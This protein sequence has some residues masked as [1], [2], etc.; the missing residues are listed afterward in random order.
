MFRLSKKSEYAILALQYLA[1]NNNRTISA[2]EISEK[3][4]IPYDFLSKILQQLLKKRFLKSIQGNLGGYVLKSPPQK[5]NLY[6]V[7]KAVEGKRGLVECLDKNKKNC[8][9]AKDCS[10][11]DNMKDININI[12]EMFKNITIKDFI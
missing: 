8:G 9:R 11:Q 6:D 5:I 10:I 1:K 12:Q 7:I 2:K 4:N 3:L